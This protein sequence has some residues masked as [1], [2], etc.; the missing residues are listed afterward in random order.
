VRG[1]LNP[2]PLKCQTRQ[3]CAPAAQAYA[4]DLRAIDETLLNRNA[5]IRFGV[6]FIIFQGRPKRFS[7][8]H[9]AILRLKSLCRIEVLMA[10]VG[11]RRSHATG[12]SVAR[13]SEVVCSCI[14]S[15]ILGHE[16]RALGRPVGP[17][18]DCRRRILQRL[19]L[20]KT[21]PVR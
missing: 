12:E 20:R 13:D 11:S 6:R 19:R 15:C 14:T 2:R 21:N 7:V 10:E 9:K 4:P 18:R 5:T 3:D 8:W 16:H 17:N 1:D